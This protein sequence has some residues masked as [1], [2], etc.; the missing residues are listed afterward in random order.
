MWIREKPESSSLCLLSW[1][2]SLLP[3][4]SCPCRWPHQDSRFCHVA[5]DP[6]LWWPCHLCLPLPDLGGSGFLSCHLLFRFF[7]LC[8][9]GNWFSA[10]NFLFLKYLVT[11]FLVRPWLTQR[12]NITWLNI[13]ESSLLFPR[14][15]H[16]LKSGH[17]QVTSGPSDANLRR[18]FEI[19][20]I[21]QYSIPLYWISPLPMT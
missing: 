16:C 19:Y 4:S 10:W 11:V 8:H 1:A 12:C 5:P 3:H 17:V 21:W 9:L 20:S 2:V 13:E 15:P 18:Y 7:V 14:S 6:G